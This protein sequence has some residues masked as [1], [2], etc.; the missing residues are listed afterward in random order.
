MAPRSQLEI[1]TSSV[2]RLVKEEASYHRESQEQ[3]E[4]IKKLES[5]Q[6]GDD[7]NKEYMLRQERLA[8]EETK[9]VL[10]SL[11]QKL[12]ESIV[13]LQG[14]LT[15]EGNKGPESNVEQINAAKDA[16]SKARTAEREIA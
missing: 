6:G 3:A 15:E 1:A 7:E 11:K 12:E 14:L 13:K 2:L 10:P 16:I 4:R 9:K 8:L 5:Q